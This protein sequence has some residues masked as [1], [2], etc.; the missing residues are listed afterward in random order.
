MDK[1]DIFCTYLSVI[2]ESYFTLIWSKVQEEEILCAIFKPWPN[3]LL[4]QPV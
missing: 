4:V 1:T 2:M 3:E